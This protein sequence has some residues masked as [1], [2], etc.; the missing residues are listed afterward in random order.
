MRPIFLA[1]SRMIGV[2]W[3]CG[4]QGWATPPGGL[5]FTQ[6]HVPFSGFGSSRSAW[7]GAG[8]LAP[9][10]GFPYARAHEQALIEMAC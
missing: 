9:S 5:A 1:V 10:V 8:A 3:M 7:L 4:T 6:K 2:N